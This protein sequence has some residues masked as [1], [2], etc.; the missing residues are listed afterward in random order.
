MCTKKCAHYTLTFA[1]ATSFGLK[2]ERSDLPNKVPIAG[3][4]RGQKTNEFKTKP[5]IVIMR[6]PLDSH[7]VTKKDFD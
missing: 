2:H 7:F 6:L 5:V 4:G 1:L 3:I